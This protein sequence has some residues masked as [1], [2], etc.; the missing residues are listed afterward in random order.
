[1]W[2]IL[3]MNTY[4][5]NASTSF[6]KPP[7]VASQITRYL[8][9]EGGTYGRASYGRIVQATARVEACRDALAGLLGVRQ[10]EKVFFTSGATAGAN[11]LLKGIGIRRGST[12][13]VSPMEHNAVMRVLYAQKETIGIEVAVLPALSDGTID[14]EQLYRIPL[15]G[16]ETCIV[17]H[18]SNVNGMIQPVEEIAAFCKKQ[19][20]PL[21]MDVSQSLGYAPVEADKWEVDA[22][23]FSGHKGLLGPTGTG[24]VYCRSTDGLI[25][26]YQGG[27][28]S[29]SDNYIM[30][31]ILPDRFE[32]GTP[33]LVG[34]VG[35]LAAIEERPVTAHTREDLLTLTAEL[36]RIP[37]IR[38]YGALNTR[39]QGEVFSL[40]GTKINP[41]ALAGRLYD[42]YG[43]E[44]RSGLHCSPLAHRTLGTFPVGTVRI[45]L[46]PYHTPADLEYLIKAVADVSR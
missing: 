26:Y 14:L 11:A 46:S 16:N 38:F 9:Q 40:S 27:T 36:S 35:L 1:M 29:N 7:G 2:F 32:A 13:W 17:N 37:D 42:K 34:I 4:F 12:V 33:N 10:P 5:D 8:N 25:P 19:H 41:S 28:G 22:L 43:I 39:R 21:I 24:G 30:P 18:Q 31:D 45:S 44:V 15:N 20:I 23:F 6:P 3:D